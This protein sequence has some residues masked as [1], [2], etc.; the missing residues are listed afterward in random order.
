MR[1]AF[2]DSRDLFG[3]CRV[4]GPA[5]AKRY[6]Q[7]SKAAIG[8]RKSLYDPRALYGRRVETRFRGLF[9]IP[10]PFPV[11]CLS[12]VSRDPRTTVFP[13]PSQAFLTTF[14]PDKDKAVWHC[15]I[16]D[17][18][19]A[20]SSRDIMGSVCFKGKTHKARC[21]DDWSD[22][23]RRQV[24]TQE[25]KP[26][27]SQKHHR[28]EANVPNRRLCLVN[29]LSTSRPNGHVPCP[30]ASHDRP[31]MFPGPQRST[32][33]PCHAGF[34]HPLF[35]QRSVAGEH[36][37]ERQRSELESD[38]SWSYFSY[39]VGTAGLTESGLI[40]STVSHIDITESFS[41]A[42][43]ESAGGGQKMET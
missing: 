15:V 21:S 14:H 31:A 24:V 39:V 1:R 30:S 26:F 32:D 34:V 38:S 13:I 43:G 29:P 25:E 40:H 36:A 42:A 8:E 22:H 4:V 2:A 17:R 27:N 10:P 6:S 41:P 20:V 16:R 19:T 23:W 18:Q 37:E 28:R 35:Y 9:P 33:Q 3:I 11:D 7:H 5:A 12:L